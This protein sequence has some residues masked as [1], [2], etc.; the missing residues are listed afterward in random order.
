VICSVLVG[1]VRRRTNETKST[2][3]MM[4]MYDLREIGFLLENKDVLTNIQ[5]FKVNSVRFDSYL[6]LK[7]GTLA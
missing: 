1:L 2:L 4:K 7:Q 6:E 5:S 3:I